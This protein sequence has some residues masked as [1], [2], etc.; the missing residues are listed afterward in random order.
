LDRQK[1]GFG[2]IFFGRVNKRKKNESCL[3]HKKRGHRKVGS[4]LRRVLSWLRWGTDLRVFLQ[5]QLMW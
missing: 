1:Y 4:V 2:K 3:V 5:G